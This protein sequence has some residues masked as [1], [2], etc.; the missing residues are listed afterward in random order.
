MSTDCWDVT[1][2][3]FLTSDT[4]AA[5]RI[6]LWTLEAATKLDVQEV[7]MAECGHGYNAL[8]WEAENWLGQPFPFRVRGFVEAMAESIRDERILL[9]PTRNPL[10]VTYHDPCNQGR[11]GGIL[12]EPRTILAKAAVD[13][14][15]MIPNRQN[16]YCC[17]GGGGMLSM[18]EFAQR[19]IDAAKIKAEQI[20]AT[21][22]KIIVTSCHNCVDQLTDV[23]RRYKLGTAVKNLCELVAD[24][25]IW[26][27]K[28]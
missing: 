26:P 20:Q 25:I 6:G 19:R 23:S 1:N 28:L 3:A 24:A 15:E 10:P 4:G 14:R 27:P 8:R 5:R 16:N 22:A 2:Y 12:Q 9:D 11:K 21:E 17:G 18:P 7:W 13:F